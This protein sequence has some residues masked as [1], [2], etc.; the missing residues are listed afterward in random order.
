M[1]RD[2]ELLWLRTSCFIIALVS[3]VHLSRP[4]IGQSPPVQLW[5]QAAEVPIMDR[6][7]NSG[8]RKSR[9]YRRHAVTVYEV[10]DGWGRVT[11]PG[12]PPMWV[13]MRLLGPSRP[14]EHAE[15]QSAYIFAD[16]RIE[17]GAIPTRPG[18]GNNAQD[19]EM[20]WRAARRA[21]DQGCGKIIDA[22]KSVSRANT[23]YIHCSGERQNRFYTGAELA[24]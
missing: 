13:E 11:L 12:H 22:D 4:A 7:S 2:T 24:R 1:L 6:P 21:L 19:V 18:S 17:D 23:Y 20:L 3:A 14:A 15:V 16:P 8:V 10:R 5:A 9:T